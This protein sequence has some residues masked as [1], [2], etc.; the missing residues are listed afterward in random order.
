MLFEEAGNRVLHAGGP[1]QTNPN[2]SG[3]VQNP[4]VAWI[5]RREPKTR[6]V[7][8]WTETPQVF[9]KRFK[10]ICKDINGNCDVEGL[11][12]KFPK[13]IQDV[14]G[15]VGYPMNR[16]WR[17]A[18]RDANMLCLAPNSTQSKRQRATRSCLIQAGASGS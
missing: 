7:Q 17:L 14:A 13:R 12:R 10:E 6:L 4:V 8:P 11:C 1:S 5:R 15:K 18:K 3:G 2:C 16:L 9:G